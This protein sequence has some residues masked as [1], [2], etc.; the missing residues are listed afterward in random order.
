[1]TY[2]VVYDLDCDYTFIDAENTEDC[3]IQFADYMGDC[4]DL[5]VKALKGC[6]TVND[7]VD[8]YNQFGQYNIQAIYIIEKTLYD[9]T[10]T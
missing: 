4:S 9:V 1:M 10:L 5:F 6:E 3:I 2:M 8:M 7:Y